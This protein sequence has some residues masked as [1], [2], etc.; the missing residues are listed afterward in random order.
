MKNQ[1][2]G[3]IGDYGK[4]G[5]LR[6]FAR[7][8][9]K[10]GVNWYL[11]PNDEKNDGNHTEYL[12][13]D[14]MRVYDEDAYDVLK[15]LAFR[16]DKTVQM[17]EKSGILDGMLFYNRVLDLDSAR[18]SE[19]TEKRDAWHRDALDALKGADLVF[20][21]PDNSLTTKKKPSQKGSEKFILPNEVSDYYK[22]GQEVVYYHH[23]SRKNDE[24]WM[25]EKTQMRE[26]LPDARIMAVAFKRW[27]RRV[28]IFVVHEE[29]ADFYKNLI[30]GFMG[31]AWGT[32][33]V[34]GKIP[35]DYESIE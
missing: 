25:Q 14:R 7:A 23:R 30:D 17:V 24:G 8:G 34:D 26:F 12:S 2:V 16:D 28:Y 9:I 18:W 27:S 3:D 6:Y 20:A 13:D 32:H 1:Y 29:K 19:R 33:R 10:V 35:F 22:R 4:Y 21:D 11:C 31:T 5:M 15:S